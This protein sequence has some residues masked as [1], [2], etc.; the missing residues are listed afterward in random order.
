ME[1]ICTSSYY[2]LCEQ[3]A[4]VVGEAMITGIKVEETKET[5]EEL[6]IAPQII[7]LLL[8]LKP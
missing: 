1:G 4:L 7:T 5:L 8:I 6:E 3:R 2:T